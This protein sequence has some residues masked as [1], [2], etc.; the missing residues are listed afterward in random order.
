MDCCRIAGDI[1]GHIDY[2]EVVQITTG[3]HLLNLGFEG[4]SAEEKGVI[5]EYQPAIMPN[6]GTSLIDQTE[7][8]F[9]QVDLS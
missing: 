5:D 1:R 9:Q 4:F 8:V 6:Q 3:T 7:P 2:F